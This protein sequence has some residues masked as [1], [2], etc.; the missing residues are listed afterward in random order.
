MVIVELLKK[1]AT[2][3]PKEGRARPTWTD[4]WFAVRDAPDE[5]ARAV[6]VECLGLD[7]D[8]ERGYAA[9]AVRPALSAE[10]KRNMKLMQDR[11]TATT[12]ARHLAA[13][14]AKR[15]EEPD[16]DAI[17]LK[18]ALKLQRAFRMRPVSYTHLTLPTKA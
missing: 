10:D 12:R 18:A 3:K 17:Q 9:E 1:A 14:L 15:L 7:G 4:A 6:L 2:P 13:R 5:E 16:R 8:L 11:A